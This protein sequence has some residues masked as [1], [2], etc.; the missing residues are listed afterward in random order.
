MNKNKKRT[1]KQVC[2]EV[3]SEN[4]L[5]ISNNILVVRVYSDILRI[6]ANELSLGE[7]LFGTYTVPRIQS[8]IRAVQRR[9]KEIKR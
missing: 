4:D 9:K 6:N 3:I 1:I 5:S 7:V 2:R 8:V